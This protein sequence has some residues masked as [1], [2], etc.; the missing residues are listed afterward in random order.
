M[1]LKAPAVF[2]IFCSCSTW[3]HKLYGI[4]MHPNAIFYMLQ[5]GTLNFTN[6][7][8]KPENGWSSPFGWVQPDGTIGINTVTTKYPN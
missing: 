5:K 4:V 3:L 8:F 1:A 6:D 2:L 7:W